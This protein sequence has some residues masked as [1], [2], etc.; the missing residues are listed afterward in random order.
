[1]RLN[2]LALAGLAFIAPSC[3]QYFSAGWTPGE[4][5]PTDAP[6]PPSFEPETKP[7]PPPRQRE[8]RFSL[9]YLLSNGGPFSQAFDRLGI[10]LTERLEAVKADSEIWDNRI[11]FITDD[12]YNDLIVNEVLTTEEK[13][14][15]V[16]F[17]IMW[18]SLYNIQARLLANPPLFSARLQPVMALA[19]PCLQTRS[20]TRLTILH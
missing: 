16:W 3:A 8:S 19:Y 6:S 2:T 15:R 20:S 14:D 12:N 18:V 7:L 13:K 4:A 11:P 10:N 5:V 9:S 1:M 17:L